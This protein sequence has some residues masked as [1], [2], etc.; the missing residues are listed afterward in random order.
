MCYGFSK[1]LCKEYLNVVTIDFRNDSLN[2]GKNYNEKYLMCFDKVLKLI[3][4]ELL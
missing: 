2:P 4:N 3:V 1:N